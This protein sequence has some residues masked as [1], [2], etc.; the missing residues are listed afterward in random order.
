M[1]SIFSRN[2][3][4]FSDSIVSYVC[5]LPHLFFWYSHYLYIFY[6]DVSQIS[7]SFSFIL[8]FFTYLSLASQ[9]L[10]LITVILFY[11]SSNVL[12][13]YS[14]FF[15]YCNFQVQ[16]LFNLYFFNFCIESLHLIRVLSHFLTTVSLICCTCSIALT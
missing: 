8:L 4:Y 5:L 16:N 13:S 3:F 1:S 6:F 11:T 15:T 9:F 7:V 14:N 10:S 2:E 12:K